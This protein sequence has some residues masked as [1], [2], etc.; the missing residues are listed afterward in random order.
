MS[1]LVG[2]E[3]NLDDETK[4]ILEGM[5]L[6]E[7]K[8]DIKMNNGYRVIKLNKKENLGKEESN[9]PLLSSPL[10]KKIILIQSQTFLLVVDSDQ[11]KFKKDE[12]KV[13]KIEDIV[14]KDL[15][16]V[17][18]SQINITPEK[19]FTKIFNV[20]GEYNLLYICEKNDSDVK[21][22]S[23]DLVERRAFQK[24]QSTFKHF[25]F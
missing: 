24:I 22:I 8:K 6:D 15:S 16:D 7:I 23:R 10:W 14:A 21:P 12:I 13:L 11:P 2:L 17:F 18:L 3:D 4:I 20:D 25:Y 9:L 5:Q 19:Q 1:V